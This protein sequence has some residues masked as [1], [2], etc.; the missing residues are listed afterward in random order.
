MNE[1]LS[2]FYIEKAK[3]EL[4]ETES[5]KEQSIR[6]FKEWLSKHP[7]IKY[8]EI[9]DKLIIKFLRAQNFQC[10]NKFRNEVENQI[11]GVRAITDC[12]GIS[13]NFY[14][15]L[16]LN[17]FLNDWNESILPVKVKEAFVI[18]VPFLQ[19]HFLTQQKLY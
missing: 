13:G 6:Q 5:K 4:G 8:P 19:L 17:Y 14:N 3:N 2:E 15:M 9:E 10:Q 7:F 1:E 11:A 12:H 16:P 18:G